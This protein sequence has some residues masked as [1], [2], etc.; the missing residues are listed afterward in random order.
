MPSKKLFQN[1]LTYLQIIVIF[2][3]YGLSQLFYILHTAYH[4][5]K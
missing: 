4:K 5:F 1:S 3:K 2:I